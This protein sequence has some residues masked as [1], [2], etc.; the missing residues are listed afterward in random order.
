MSEAAL[1]YS[2]N[3]LTALLKRFF[4]AAHAS[5]IDVG[6]AA[7]L[8]CWMEQRKLASISWLA[9][10]AEALARGVATPSAEDATVAFAAS[11]KL[12]DQAICVA[13]VSGEYVVSTGLKA[14]PSLL[15]A[16]LARC[17]DAGLSGFACW[18][19][20]GGRLFIARSRAQEKEPELLSGASS[21][22]SVWLAMARDNTRLDRCLRTEGL[23]FS[24]QE[25]RVEISSEE[26]AQR[27]QT[28]LDGGISV[29]PEDIAKIC[30]IA[31]RVLVESSELSRMGAGD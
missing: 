2:R 16:G 10:Q 31:D 30:V 23:H 3:E 1:H 12:F 4:E 6:A 18:P 28:S 22:V 13:N 25:L 27:A 15:L 21:R 8:A 5:M 7:E 24:E 17:A 14:E 29:G 9:A 11:I 26:F 20:E 19:G